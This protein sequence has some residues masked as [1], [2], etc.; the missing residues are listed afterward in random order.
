M[1]PLWIIRLLFLSLC[2]TAGYAISQV[3]PEFTGVPYSAVFGM[4]VGLVSAD[5]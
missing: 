1:T 3:R 5:C 4:F 2:T